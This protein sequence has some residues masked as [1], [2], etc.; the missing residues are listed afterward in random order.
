MVVLSFSIKRKRPR[1][2][3]T[4]VDRFRQPSPLH[5]SKIEP[6]LL[7]FRERVVYLNSNYASSK[8]L[9]DLVIILPGIWI[10]PVGNEWS[11]NDPNYHC[12]NYKSLWQVS[13]RRDLSFSPTV[14]CLC[15]T[16]SRTCFRQKE[17]LF[18]KHGDITKK[19]NEATQN[20]NCNSE[21]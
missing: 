6:K 5:T 4:L 19:D 17:L 11:S 8:L 9:G 18:Q 15:G 21:W 16:L 12:H 13:D 2:L 20:S 3:F 7:S 10:N 1:L 14:L